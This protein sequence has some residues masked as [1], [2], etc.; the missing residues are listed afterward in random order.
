MPAL[1]GRIYILPSRILLATDLTDLNQILPEGI[2]YALRCK[3]ALKLIHVLPDVSTPD[4]RL[5]RAV[6]DDGETAR[7]HAE[8]VLEEA[9]KK[10]RKAGVKSTWTVRSG[11][12]T[13]TIVQMVG[14]WRAD[15]IVVGSHGPRKFQQEV[16]G[17]VAESIFRD[18][19]IPVLTIGPAAQANRQLSEQ[20]R[21]LLTT[22]LDRQS[23][24]ICESVVRFARIH[25]AD[26][27][28][29]HV[30]P[31]IAEAH[32]SAVRIRAYA[33]STFKEILS[34]IGGEV[35][36]VSCTVETGLVVETILRI[37]R[38]R[39]F[40]LIILAGVSSA[41]FRTDI[42][43]GTAYG[44]ICRAPCPVLVLNEEAYRR[45]N[46]ASGGIAEMSHPIIARDRIHGRGS[47]SIA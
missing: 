6:P 12:V 41:S 47:G 23:R 8:R 22:A 5:V 13:P 4:S 43:P 1:P 39:R 38:Q 16:L 3:A 11:P 31:E 9:S 32:P 19:D 33:E 34:S 24:H 15:R 35:Q 30:I 21:I 10:A 26:L 37:A 27:T 46:Q 18:V 20:R 36:P 7:Q 17:S 42:M 40:D 45:S 44:V 25:Q 14:E 2:D 29:L 28:M